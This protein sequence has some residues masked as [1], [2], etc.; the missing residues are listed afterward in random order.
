M[1]DDHASM[2]SC[3]CVRAGRLA[4]I[5]SKDTRMVCLPGLFAVDARDVGAIVLGSILISFFIL[6]LGALYT[7]CTRTAP[8]TG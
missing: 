8:L 6:T 7:C 1:A 3:H 5:S 4:G 2:R